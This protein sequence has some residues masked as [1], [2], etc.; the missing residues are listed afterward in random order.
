M[1]TYT[2]VSKHGIG[3][4]CFQRKSNGDILPVAYLSRSVSA[5]EAKYYDLTL[6]D[7]GA[8]TRQLELLALI[9]AL[10]QLSHTLGVQQNVTLWTDHRNILH[11]A[12]Q[13]SNSTGMKGN[14]RLLRWALKL[15]QWPDLK[16]RYQ[17]GLRN[18]CA[19]A[20]SRLYSEAKAAAI[21]ALDMENKILSVEEFEDGGSTLWP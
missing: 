19:D 1:G 16:I 14:D 4:F 13:G 9:W 15:S 8:D 2:D 12:K 11:L 17:P 18:E 21:A 20:L 6:G 7:T 5:A 3:A 10:D